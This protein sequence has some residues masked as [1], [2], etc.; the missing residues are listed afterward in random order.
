MLI[1][2]DDKLHISP[3]IWGQTTNVTITFFA[4]D[5][6]GHSFQITTHYD[7]VFADYDNCSSTT[8]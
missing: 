6:E 7:I 2:V 5:D 4:D 3:D 8:G 1:D